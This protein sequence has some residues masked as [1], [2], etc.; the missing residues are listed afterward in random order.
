MPPLPLAAAFA[1]LPD[2]RRETQNK[3]HR[4]SDVLVIATCAVIGGAE[5]WDA[6]ALF[7]RCKEAFF[8]RFL[9]LDNGI[10]SPDT[11]ERV[12]AKLDPAA[13]AAAFGRW[14]TAAFATTGLVPI[15]IDG[16]SVRGAK[17]ATATGCLH[18][19]SAWATEARLTLGQVSVPDG[20]NEIAVVP[21]LLAALDL[22]GAVVTLDAAGC[23]TA[24]ARQI[25]DQGGDYL[26]AVK[27]N[28]PGLHAAVAGVFAAACAADFAGVTHDT[29]G[30]EAAGHGRAEERYVTVIADPAGLPAGWPDVAAVVQVNRERTADG[31][32]TASTHYYI[33]SRRGTAAELAGLIRGHWGIEALHWVLDVVYRE[34][35][36][37]I[38]AGHAGANLAMIRKVA[39]ALTRRAPGK[40]SGVTKR[41]MAGW[42]D[43]YLLKVLQG[44]PAQ[45]VR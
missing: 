22:A 20:A 42:D 1:D 13:F 2:P 29:A 35:D 10:P 44:F 23:Q 43:D 40:Q 31:R 17:K 8:R 25:R 30:S 34:D 19:V 4:L 45:V 21:D 3:L 33:T 28:Q 9:P 12:F 39:V 32:T 5:T 41:L 18:L 27:G 26:L 15:A 14:L 11:F 38:R 37:R 36:S 16:K 7:G 24:I 6:I